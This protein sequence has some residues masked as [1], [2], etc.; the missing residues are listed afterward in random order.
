MSGER[1]PWHSGTYVKH[2]EAVRNRANADP[3]YRCWRCGRT[4]SE[5]GTA[6]QAGHVIDGQVGGELRAECTPCN[7]SA[8]AT[9]GNRMR[10]QG[11]TRKW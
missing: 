10:V 7:T 5:H 6:W 4:R 2:A 11:V 3:T 8:G 9:R 1:K